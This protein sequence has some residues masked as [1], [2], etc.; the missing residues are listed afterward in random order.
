V[1]NV[2]DI[3]INVAAVVIVLQALRGARIDGTRSGAEAGGATGEP[4]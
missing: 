1:F 3:C 4:S 2:A